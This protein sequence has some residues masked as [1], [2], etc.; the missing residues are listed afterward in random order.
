MLERGEEIGLAI[1][2]QKQLNEAIVTAPDTGIYLLE[3]L[4]E[5]LAQLAELLLDGNTR[6]GKTDLRQQCVLLRQ[7]VFVDQVVLEATVSAALR[8][9]DVT[10]WSPWSSDSRPSR[11]AS[12]PSIIAPR[13]A[14]DRRLR[15]NDSARRTTSCR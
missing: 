10:V 2:V 14:S 4:V 11:S 13:R 1:G 6:G 8:T 15:S 9:E 5:G 12:S 3:T 7:G